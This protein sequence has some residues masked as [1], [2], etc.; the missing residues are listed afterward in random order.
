MLIDLETGELG[1]GGTTEDQQAA[2][3]GISDQEMADETAKFKARNLDDG[4]AEHAARS[5]LLTRKMIEREK[6]AG[7]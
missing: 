2:Q 6:K 3:A 5:S 1:F 4:Q 7:R